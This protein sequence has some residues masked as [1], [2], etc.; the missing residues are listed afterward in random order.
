[1]KPR[2][3]KRM[4]IIFTM[5]MFCTFFNSTRA[6]TA[7]YVQ[8]PTED[9]EL[10]PGV[11]SKTKQVTVTGYF[12]P[13]KEDYTKTA[14]YLK[15]IAMNGAG[16]K[17]ASGKVPSIGTVAADTRYYP[18]GTKIYIPELKFSGTVRDTGSGIKGSGRMDIFCGHGKKAEQIAKALGRKKV[19]LMIVEAS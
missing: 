1:M 12:G 19:T 14:Q 10:L 9:K 13:V 11:I 16:K 5:L 7:Q 2:S 4:C 18:F 17:T 15:A 6:Y 3:I 8:P